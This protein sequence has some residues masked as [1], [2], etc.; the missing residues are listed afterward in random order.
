[1]AARLKTFLQAEVPASSPMPMT[2]VEEL[3]RLTGKLKLP[4]LKELAKAVGVT[5]TV[6][7]GQKAK[8][9][10]FLQITGR[11]LGEA[12]L[13]T[14]A[15]TLRQWANEPNLESRLADFLKP[16]TATQI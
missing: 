10:I 13:E 7:T 5:D 9:K 15:E 8:E 2:V 14:Q 11:N 1:Y 12:I 3:N 16:L 6:G 4:Q